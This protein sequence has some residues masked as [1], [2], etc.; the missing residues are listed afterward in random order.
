MQNLNYPFQ[1]T[2][3]DSNYPFPLQFPPEFID[4]IISSSQSMEDDFYYNETVDV[5]D[6]KTLTI[7]NGK[8]ISIR[9]SKI[10][11][12][13]PSGEEKL[14][15][16]LDGQI[17]RQWDI[18]RPF[19]FL[20]R[21]DLLLPNH[22]NY[23]TEGIII[24]IDND[25]KKV[26]IRYKNK[27]GDIVDEWI[28]QESERI[29]K[30]GSHCG[31]FDPSNCD[32]DT[33]NKRLY[34]KRKF[35]QLNSIQEKK[36]RNGMYKVNMCIKE[37]KGD[38]NCMFRAISDQVY[39]DEIYHEIIRDKCMDYIEMEKDFFSQ[40][41]EGGEDSFEEYVQMKRTLGVWGDDIELQAISE[42]YNRPIEIYSNAVKPLKTFH[43]D[44]NFQRGMHEDKNG[45]LLVKK[46]LPIKVS[47][48]GKA[49]YNSIVP[50]KMN[51]QYNIFVNN[52][53]KK[54]PGEV[55]DKL[56]AQV[57]KRNEQKQIKNEMNVNNKEPIIKEENVEETVVKND[58]EIN[59][60]REMFIEKSKLIFKL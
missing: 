57:R 48:H 31:K 8:I 24:G 12:Q 15:D 50:N 37:V 42:M 44:E 5:I 55:E 17:L 58:N 41:I 3:P 45:E 38:G 54:T 26:Q 34:A 60:A 11:I 14:L 52:L 1:A 13:L 19:Q 6:T 49:H 4:N 16:R 46:K 27:K 56:I 22:N 33:I 59:K 25:N 43:E 20:N 28:H 29:S 40:F 35:F 18:G 10:I 36:L 9:G 53:I 32:S 39:G 2:S 21:V 47:Y 51:T 7:Q 30:V 23:W